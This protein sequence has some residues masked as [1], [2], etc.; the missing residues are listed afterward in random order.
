MAYPNFL[1]WREQT[2]T[3][4]E[5]A[6]FQESSYTLTGVNEPE[7]LSARNV[8]ANFFKALGVNPLLGRSFTPDEDQPGGNRTV[9]LG[10]ASWQ[11]RFAGATNIIGQ[12]LELNNEIYTVIGVLPATFE[13]ESPVDIFTPIGLEARDLMDRGN[14]PGIYGLGLLKSNVTEAQSRAEL[15]A[16]AQRLATQYPGTNEG[17]SV[18][19]ISFGRTGLPWTSAPLYYFYLP[20]SDCVVDRLRQCRELVIGARGDAIEG[21]D[22][23]RGSRRRPMENH[24]AVID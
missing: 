2:R 20:P 7:R 18:S 24:E 16:I 10:H 22:G 13:W 21:D 11:R 15:T 12:R 6:A 4:D 8:S 3:F 23:S 19:L 17:I 5:L 9:I 1:D 14:H